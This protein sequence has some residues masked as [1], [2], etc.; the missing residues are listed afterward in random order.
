M[1]WDRLSGDLCQ[2][3]VRGQRNGPNIVLGLIKNSSGQTDFKIRS[4][5]IE[6]VFVFVCL[7]IKDYLHSSEF[8]L[9]G[10]KFECYVIVVT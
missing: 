1:G 9:P 4:G 10:I 2:M 7:F 6:L 8:M 5:Y 3:W